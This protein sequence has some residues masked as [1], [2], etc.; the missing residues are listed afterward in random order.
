MRNLSNYLEDLISNS[1]VRENKLLTDFLFK[2]ATELTST[3]KDDI[4]KRK[5]LAQERE[6]NL[7]HV[8]QE[9]EED[10]RLVLTSGKAL[11]TELLAEGGLKRGSTTIKKTENFQDLPPSFLKLLQ[12]LKI[13]MAFGAYKELHCNKKKES[14]LK[15]LRQ[16]YSM[17]PWTVIKGLVK[18]TNPIKIMI[19]LLDVFLAR[20][21]GGRNLLQRMAKSFFDLENKE[22]MLTEIRQTI[23]NDAMCEKI[24][25]FALAA[26]VREKH[27]KSKEA[28]KKTEISLQT[29]LLDKDVNPRFGTR[30]VEELSDKQKQYLFQLWLL[31]I[32]V[33]DH[34]KFIDLIGTEEFVRILKELANALYMP[35][36]ACY[37]SAN[38]SL[39]I[40]AIA[41]ALKEIT[42]VAADL[43][44]NPDKD[45]KSTF[46]AYM[47]I[48][49]KHLPEVYKFVR[50]TLLHD[51]TGIIK[52]IIKWVARII[53]FM[54]KG[55]K[56]D[57]IVNLQSLLSKL[58]E[59]QRK[60]LTSEVDALMQFRNWRR[61]MHNELVKKK[62]YTNY[63]PTLFPFAVNKDDVT[64]FDLVEEDEIKKMPIPKIHVSPARFTKMVKELISKQYTS[65]VWD[66]TKPWIRV[67]SE[68]PNYAKK[69]EDTEK[70]KST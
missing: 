30:E 21:F 63:D 16:L 34:E 19:K 68:E 45:P 35:L 6:K 36:S 7:V 25:N 18:M 5:K 38:L 67:T 1:K 26:E 15:K 46:K 51:K 40:G 17:T 47:D 60:Q 56:P 64:E 66:C 2:N 55:S 58:N 28:Q 12:W 49:D 70:T 22:Y 13:K 69:K 29:I 3:E 10:C 61:T 11:L 33:I 39:L 9:I 57:Q 32:K 54:R 48:I 24:H 20:P 44:E 50:D 52:E 42:T 59:A 14:K 27:T 62:V 8:Q 65:K 53:N 23:K 37:K 31:E 4:E 41:D 43:Q